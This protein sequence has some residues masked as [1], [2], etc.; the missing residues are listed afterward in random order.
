MYVQAEAKPLL[1]KKRKFE[2][3]ENI[4]QTRLLG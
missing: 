1:P 4:S 2:K 3:A